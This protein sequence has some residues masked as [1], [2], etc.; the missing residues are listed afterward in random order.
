MKF[1][2]DV[3]EQIKLYQSQ[4]YEIGKQTTEYITMEKSPGLG[5]H[6]L[7]F[8]LTSWFTLGLGNVIFYFV[9]KKRK[10]IMF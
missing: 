10:K 2:N 7:I 6:L 4:D 9:G 8:F 5:S 1:S 3:K